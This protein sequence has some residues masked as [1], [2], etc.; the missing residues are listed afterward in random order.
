MELLL[1]KPDRLEEPVREEP[2]D[3]PVLRLVVIVAVIAGLLL[4]TPFVAQVCYGPG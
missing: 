3:N 2:E 4:A 1:V